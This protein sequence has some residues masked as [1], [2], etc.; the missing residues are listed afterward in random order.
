MQLIPDE[1]LP[2]SNSILFLTVSRLIEFKEKRF[3]ISQHDFIISRLPFYVRQHDRY[4]CNIESFLPSLVE[5][6]HV[7]LEN[8]SV[9]CVNLKRRTDRQTE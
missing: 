5:F 4:L 3:Q 9:V 7:V 8:M 2:F 6:G 1:H